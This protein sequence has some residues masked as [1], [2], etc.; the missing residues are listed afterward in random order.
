MRHKRRLDARGVNARAVVVVVV[1]PYGLVV[2]EHRMDG[3]GWI[4]AASD[5]FFGLV[6]PIRRGV[7]VIP[8][9]EFRR[10]ADECKRMASST[11]GVE[12]GI[13]ARF[14]QVRF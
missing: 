12:K 1:D 8:S 11:R 9:D 2:H 3:E 14:Y 10:Q 4:Q 13:V 7:A 6:G 5:L